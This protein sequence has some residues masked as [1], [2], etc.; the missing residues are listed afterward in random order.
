L[1]NHGEIVSSLLVVPA[2]YKWPFMQPNDVQLTYVLTHPK[3]RGKAYAAQLIYHAMQDLKKMNMVSDIWYVTDEN[4]TGSVKLA[5]KIGFKQ[6]GL[7]RT[8]SLL[9]IL[10]MV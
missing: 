4:N 8:T 9:R 7:A 10:K 2:Y 5:E 3:H 1:K 6:V